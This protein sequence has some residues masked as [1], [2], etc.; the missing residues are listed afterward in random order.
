MALFLSVWNKYEYLPSRKVRKIRQVTNLCDLVIDRRGEHFVC[1]N[2][3]NDCHLKNNIMKA[4]QLVFCHQNIPSSFFFR[5]GRITS[6][7]PA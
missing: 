7:G 4:D 2:C 6:I 1:R 3:T 5:D